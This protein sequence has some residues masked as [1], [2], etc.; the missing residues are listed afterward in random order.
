MMT[1][2]QHP[3]EE[4]LSCRLCPRACG[5]NRYKTTGFCGAG[6]VPKLARA[7]LHLWEEPCISGKRGSGAVFFSGCTLRC[8]FCQNFSLSHENFGRELPGADGGVSSL[9][10]IFL[11]LQDEGAETLNLV[12][13]TQ[14]LPTVLRSLDRVKHRLSIPIVLNCGGYE[15]VET[16][17][18]LNGYIDVYLPDFKYADSAPAKR[19]S[20]AKDYPER[21]LAA[22]T[23]MI[24]QCG[25]EEIDTPPEGE[26]LK[27][28]VIIRHMVLPSLRKDSIT[29]LNLLHD[30]LPEHHWLL[31]L[32]SQYTPF[33]KAALFPEI[34]RRL[35]SFEY[36]SVLKEARRLDLRGY[37]Q[38]RTSAKEE[39]TP[40]FDLSG[41]P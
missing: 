23:E 30:T 40:P 4:Y 29:V 15:T 26:I 33:Y 31:S 20:A 27:R 34:N 21:A 37:M 17:R 11:R 19:Y 12:T 2:N 5:V 8:C 32:M 1:Q 22:L 7:A 16:I 36:D 38:A 9:S 28:G 25:E 18:L 6:T 3:I 41:V 24:A 39:Y 35:T 10:D 14:Y 13:P